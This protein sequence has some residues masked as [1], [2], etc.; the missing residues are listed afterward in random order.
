MTRLLIALKWL[1][2]QG[3]TYLVIVAAFVTFAAPQLAPLLSPHFADLVMRVAI[4]IAAWAT[5]AVKLARW[6]PEA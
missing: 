4:N 6:R 2:K 5:V 1:A 3:P